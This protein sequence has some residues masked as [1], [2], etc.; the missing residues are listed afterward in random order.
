M[1][2]SY[3]ERCRAPWMSWIRSLWIPTV[4]KRKVWSASIPSGGSSVSVSLTCDALTVTVQNSPGA[5]SAAG[6]SVYWPAAHP[7]A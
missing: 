4:V 2:P 3:G 7:R 5:K 1:R 6:S